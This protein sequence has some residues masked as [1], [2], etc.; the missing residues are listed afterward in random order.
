MKKVIL[1]S[2]LSLLLHACRR[3]KSP[4]ETYD[5]KYHQSPILSHQQLDSVLATLEKVPFEQLPAEYLEYCELNG[6]FRA[7]YIG[8]TFYRVKGDEMYRFIVNKHRIKDFLPEDMFFLRV[9]KNH[10]GDQ[11]LLLDPRILHK[12]MDLVLKL[13]ENGYD[14]NELTVYYGFRHPRYNRD[15]GGASLSMHMKGI[16]VDVR[17]GDLDR[18]GDKDKHDKQIVLGFLENDII[19][20]EGGIGKYPG[21]QCVH[22]D[23]RGSRARW[24]DF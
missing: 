8:K 3:E 7:N 6:R 19:K 2:V 14:Y 10:G 5:Q 11:Y 12:L 18:D 22:M 15:I 13:K 17:V 20:N 24:D 1:L 23:V 9:V 4:E 21:T 16:A